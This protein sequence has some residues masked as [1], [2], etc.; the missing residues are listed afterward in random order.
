M[1]KFIPTEKYLDTV[2]LALK[3]GTNL[4]VAEGTIRSSKTEN[5]K[6]T[7]M[8][9][10]FDSDEE[11]HLIA[12]ND[13]DAINDNI[14]NG[15]HGL[16]NM[17]PKHLAIQRDEIGGYYIAVK[18]RVPM[19]KPANKRILLVGFSSTAKWK[20]ILGKTLGVILIDEV[21]TANKQ[22]VDECFARQASV[23]KPL[24]L[25]TLNGD[26]PTHW[27]Y[28]DY[29]NRCKIVSKYRHEVPASIIAD[30]DKVP[31]E[32]GWYY[33][34]WNFYNN[35]VM[36]EEEI[37]RTKSIYPIGSYYYTIKILGERG[38]PGR[39]IYID[40]MDS[41]KLLKK[42]DMSTV[43]REYPYC[44]IG[45][46]I[47]ANRALNSFTLTAYYKDLSRGVF[48]TK[49]S[50]KQLGY[51]QKT[52]ELISFV[53]LWLSRGANIEAISVDSAEANYIRDLKA[54]FI[55]LRLPEVIPSYKAT[56]KERIDLNIITFSTGR[57]I[58]NDTPEG[59]DLYDAFKMAK[60]VDGKAN[61]EREDLNEPHNDKIDSAEYSQTRHM[62]RMLSV[63]KRYDMDEG[64]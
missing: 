38:A 27:I 62:K 43:F 58:F 6:P 25:W 2:T 39:L 15:E 40:Y 41:N 8:F 1:S 11:L 9:S 17:F 34:H 29:I 45:I 14:L 30:M 55:S 37:R 57:M 28:T 56:I 36:G 53:R 26:V 23:K 46:D 7:F 4:L 52:E 20:K 59:R 60:W 18:G 64:A 50:F 32:K 51:E 31:K 16:M 44:D 24:Q 19:N 48:I 61:E 13:L 10:V 49:H 54:K 12:A 5:F 47:G 35:P 22:F 33:I 3:P 42:L 63:V 21:N